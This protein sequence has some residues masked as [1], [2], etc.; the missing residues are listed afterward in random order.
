MKQT[1]KRL[2][3]EYTAI[4][5][6]GNKPIPPEQ[7]VRRKRD[8]QFEGLD[9]HA[10]RLDASTGW[11]YYPSSITMA[12]KQLLVVDGTHGHIHPGVNSDFCKSFQMSVFF[13]LPEIKSPCNRTGCKQHTVRAHVFLIRIVS[14][15]LSQLVVTVVQVHTATQSRTDTTHTRGPRLKEHSVCVLPQNSHTPSRNV[16]CYTSLDN[17]EHVHSFLIFDTV[18]LTCLLSEPK[19]CADPRCNLGGALAELPPFTVEAK[20]NMSV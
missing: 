10:C 9:E 15:C 11:R 3:Q 12:T 13:R 6:S 18:F 20:A 8:Q 5:G 17:T 14:A 2:H 7:Q 19:P 4:T 1:C 16:T